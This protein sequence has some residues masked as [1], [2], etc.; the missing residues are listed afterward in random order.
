MIMLNYSCSMRFKPAFFVVILSPMLYY[1]K[2]IAYISLN[3]CL[4]VDP[5]S[6]TAS[7]FLRR[8]FWLW[9][10]INIHYVVKYVFYDTK[11]PTE[12]SYIH[13]QNLTLVRFIVSSLMHLNVRLPWVELDV[14]SYNKISLSAQH[15]S[16]NI[17]LSRTNAI[18]VFVWRLTIKLNFFQIWIQPYIH[19]RKQQLLIDQ[20]LITTIS[21]AWLY[22]LRKSDFF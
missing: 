15:L 12:I 19:I 14:F 7:L 1:P 9:V 2:T 17:I 6:K 13:S 3:C 11:S 20:S 22:F 10:C 21:I 4:E 16:E 18:R 8:K 5:A